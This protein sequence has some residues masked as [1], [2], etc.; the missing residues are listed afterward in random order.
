MGS[1][2]QFSRKKFHLFAMGKKKCKLAYE[3][4]TLLNCLLFLR[5]F[6]LEPCFNGCLQLNV[7]V[8]A[9]TQCFRIILH[10]LLF[11]QVASLSLSACSPFNA[12]SFCD[13][14]NIISI[15]YT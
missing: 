7:T 3:L 9:L 13:P 11:S 2:N 14:S 12:M 8:C 6:E 4:L 5:S 15:N 1:N 10:S